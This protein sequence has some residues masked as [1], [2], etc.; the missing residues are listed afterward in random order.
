VEKEA[1]RE[2]VGEKVCIRY[3]PQAVKVKDIGKVKVEY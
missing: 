3:C 2:Y 1:K